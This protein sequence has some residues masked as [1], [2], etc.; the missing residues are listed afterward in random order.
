MSSGHDGQVRLVAIT[1]APAVGKT[2][3]A[4]RLARR[5]SVPAATLDTDSLANVWPWTADNALYRL[6][7]DNL[8]ATLPRL[9]AWGAQVIVLSGVLLPG[10]VLAHVADLLE[11]PQFDWVWYALRAEPRTLAA[12]VAGEHAVQDPQLRASMSGLDRRLDE[13]ASAGIDARDIVT[14][15]LDADA[16]LEQVLAAEAA[17]GAPVAGAP[18]SGALVSGAPV[19]GALVSGALV[20]GALAAPSTAAPDVTLPRDV[21]HR[22][23]AAALTARGV[24]ADAAAQCAAQLIA[25]EQDGYPSHGLVRIVEYCGALDR[26]ELD[27]AARPVATTDGA[28]IAID[29][30]RAL[31]V[32][33][34][35][36]IEHALTSAQGADSARFVR[37]SHGGHLGRL[38]PLAARATQA[39]VVV[40]GF[41]NYSGTGQ[42]VAPA[43]SGQGRLGT[44]PI[45][46]ACPAG[47]DRPVVVDISTSAWSEGAVRIAARAGSELPAG[48]LVG[49]YGT[50]VRD[51]KRLYAPDAA[52]H[53]ALAPLGWGPAGT[54]HKGFAL[55][56][57][58]ELL[59]GALG[60]DVVCAHDAFDGVG[61]NSAFFIAFDP[62]AVGV[63]PEALH[64]H[65]LDLE[66]HVAA[67]DPVEPDRP[68]R[69]PGRGA[70]RSARG[71][72]TLPAALADELELLAHGTGHAS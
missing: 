30:N 63:A 47:D 56:V 10:D 15:G 37:V 48:V 67:A 46:F 43:G 17:A 6:V 1:G 19:S 9:R 14:D 38:G 18:V 4:Q 31:G 39:G 2:T 41:C 58:A 69:L 51:P 28:T 33:V 16:V 5:Y 72:V 3:V 68:V 21:V 32:H 36:E 50:A 13:L 24:D 70:A 44:N 45:V 42:K 61:G 8:R 52:M 12:R 57:A 22:L 62:A 54:A 71:Q 53:T 7:A 65:V 64:R 49:R 66:R 20:S 11:D 29:G 26:G 27:P 55:A 59:G 35:R 60:G 40:L 25:A 23:A 34:L